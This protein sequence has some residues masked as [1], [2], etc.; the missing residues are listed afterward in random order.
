[1]THIRGT[2]IAERPDDMKV[3]H[4]EGD[5]RLD[6]LGQ[7]E[8]Q[9]LYDDD[10]SDIESQHEG[11]GSGESDEEMESDIGDEVGTAEKP[12]AI[13]QED[14][15]LRLARIRVYNMAYPHA[16]RGFG[17]FLPLGT[18]YASYS[19]TLPAQNLGPDEVPVTNTS[20][21]R[22][23]SPSAPVP[24]VPPIPDTNLD[25]ESFDFSPF[26][27]D[28]GVD[29]D[30]DETSDGNVNENSNV[31]ASGPSSSP[32]L[33]TRPHSPPKVHL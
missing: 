30:N 7:E 9:D 31:V 19:P 32:F 27:G 2:T 33:Y 5:D 1:M 25:L 29:N 14:D 3:G 17:P 15:V 10:D 8:A 18:H 26:L 4:N 28:D 6:P 11:E 12:A 21:M 23:G 20:T 16:S 13:S 24:P 22:L